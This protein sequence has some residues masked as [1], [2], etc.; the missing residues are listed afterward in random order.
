MTITATI[1]ASCFI[2]DHDLR[3][4]ESAQEMG[5][6]L[7]ESTQWVSGPGGPWWGTFTVRVPY[8]GYRDWLGFIDQRRGPNRPFVI[9]PSTRHAR[10][11]AAPGTP[12]VADD[13][14]TPVVG[15]SGGVPVVGLD[16]A[17]VSV[18]AAQYATQ[19]TISH[20]GSGLEWTAGPMFNLAGRM[21]RVAAVTSQNANAAVLE[22][23]PRLRAAVPVTTTLATASVAMRLASR[24]TGR[25]PAPVAYNDAVLDV[26][27]FFE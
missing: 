23:V 6:S 13:S 21:Y 8:S 27:E 19:I 2:I 10:W 15:I 16:S 24:E 4:R 26:V 3:V 18:A 22:I 1:P 5:E 11:F 25:I 9:Y 20:E 17:F 12:V 14:G 7:A